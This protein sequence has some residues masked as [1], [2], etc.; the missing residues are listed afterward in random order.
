MSRPYNITDFE[1]VRPGDSEE[2]LKL[3]QLY[4]YNKIRRI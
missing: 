1:F 4:G 2:I 3:R